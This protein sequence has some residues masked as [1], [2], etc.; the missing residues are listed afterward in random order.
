MMDE[1]KMESRIQTLEH[2][3]KLAMILVVVNMTISFAALAITFVVL[4]TSD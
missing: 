2:T 3:L 1:Q 4:F